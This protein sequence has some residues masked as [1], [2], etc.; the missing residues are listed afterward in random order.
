MIYFICSL[1]NLWVKTLKAICVSRIALQTKYFKRLTLL[2]LDF[3]I[4]YIP[5]FLKLLL[6]PLVTENYLEHCAFSVTLLNYTTTHLDEIIGSSV[7]LVDL[8]QLPSIGTPHY[9]YKSKLL[10]VFL[11]Y[12]LNFLKEVHFSSYCG[13]IYQ[14]DFFP[15]S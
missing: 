14:L 10:N 13:C 12:E 6:K 2:E 1:D 7:F 8:Y 9:F 11:V 15:F 3:G 4:K 5:V